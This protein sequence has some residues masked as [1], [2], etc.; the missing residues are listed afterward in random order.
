METKP[1][2]EFSPKGGMKMEKKFKGK[3]GQGPKKK[4]GFTKEGHGAQKK[5]GFSKDGQG[6]EKRKSSEDDEKTD[7]ADYKLRKKELKSHRQETEKKDIYV[8]LKDCTKEKKT[9]LM[10]ELHQMIKGKIKQFSNH[11]QRQEVFEDLK[12]DM[13]VLSKSKYGRHLVKKLLMHGK[14]ELVGSVIQSFKGSVRVMLRHAN[15]SSII[16]YAYNDK[17][18]LAQRLMLT[19]ELYGNTFTLCKEMIEAIREAVVYMAYTHD[20]ARV[21]MHCLWHGTPKDRKVIIKTMKTYMV[22]FA[23]GEFGHLVLLS[24]FDCVDDTKLI[25]QTVLAELLTSLDEV[26]NNKYGKKVL[27]YLLN[28]RDPDH[29]LPEVIRFLEKGDNNAHSKKEPATRKKE[30]LEVV[31]PPL[32][33]HLQ[34]NASTMVRDK[35]LSV[36]VRDILLS[37]VGDLRPAMLAVVQPA[38]LELVPGGVEGQLH[39]AEHPAGHMVLKWLIEQDAL[40]AKAE[41]EERFSRILVDTVGV[42]QLR[43][44]VCVNRGALVLCSLLKCVDQS[45]VSEVRSGLTA[46]LPKLKKVTNNRGVENIVEQLT[47]A[48]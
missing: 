17:A 20:G 35:G 15:A 29:I 30:L 27:L 25:K 13:V 5:F 26:I 28:P 40:L 12:A 45:V 46:I 6:A 34:D 3:E 36:M 39:M 48:Q 2:K 14:K 31:S 24:I 4:F 32:L 22:K 18:V 33:Q 8:I 38:S 37:A 16:E 23:T 9:K 21:A 11:E 7:W 43:S 19:E 10:D 41:R 47:A 44:W 1:K 42:D